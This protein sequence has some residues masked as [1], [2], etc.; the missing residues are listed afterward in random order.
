MKKFLK[1]KFALTDSGAK[2]V[3]IA[4]AISFC[5]NLG[6]MAFMMVA[7]YFGDNV[8]R[9]NRQS[10]GHYLFIIAIVTVLVYFLVDLEYVKT[11]N[12]TY[13]EAMNLR[14]D[15]AERLKK[16]PISY[17]SKH[18]LSD[19]AQTIMQD[20]SD[21]EHAMS[22]AIPRCFGYVFFLL[23]ISVLLLISNP[24]LGLSVI[25]PLLLGLC[26]MLVSKN[27]QKKGSEKYFWRNRK[28]AEAFQ[29][30]IEMQREIKSYGMEEETLKEIESALEE[31]E[32]IRLKSEMGQVLPILTSLSFMK[33]TLGSVTVVAASLLKADAIDLIYVIGFLLASVR[34]VDAVA[35]IEENFAEMFYID[36]RVKRIN[37][38]RKTKIQRG[39][40]I[41]IREFTI[42]FQE[43]G[44]SYN[45]EVKVLDKVNFTAKQNEVTAIVGP[46]GCGKSTILRLISRLY[47]YNQGKILIGGI[48]IQKLDTD[49][50]FEKVS[51]VFQD[52][53]LFNTS[54]LENIRMGRADATDE[55]VK[56]A[57][58]MANCEEFIL[59]LPD[60]YHTWIGENG[61]QLSGGERQR[62][63]I[64]RA[65]LKNAPIL[66]LD[67]ISASLDVEN[68][69]KIQQALNKLMQGKTIVVVSHR[70]KSIEKVDKIV[71]M[72]SGKVVAEGKHEDLLKNSPLYRKLIEKSTM[73]A[74]FTY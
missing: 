20:V 3:C 37:E 26:M 43:V 15:I 2:A 71:V 6:Y 51:F 53:I 21:I 68:E 42:D 61:S 28:H 50:L 5:L 10:G 57:A 25:L 65:F 73:A 54:I 11:F 32:K 45:D 38:L 18:N 4:A 14:L 34:L 48:D 70:M 27:I 47:D 56:N 30:T 13:E 49:A 60:G 67:E 24:Y 33:L 62:I 66:L 36:A 12:A 69:M 7:M 19:L 74:S 9:G 39:E 44:F 41:D 58:R 8:L 59:K 16:L 72:E 31:S 46:S 29:E 17:F 40:D 35:A 22:H 55:E 23:A 63:S 1:K 52:V 64:A